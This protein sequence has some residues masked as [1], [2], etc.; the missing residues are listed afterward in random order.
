MRKL[1]INS[2]LIASVTLTACATDRN[3]LVPVGLPGVV[4]NLPGVHRINIQQGNLITQEMV[5]ELK[6]GMT[7]QQVRFLL[8]TPLLVDS[9]HPDRWD[10]LYTNR[11]ESK[12]A[13]TPVEQK[14]LSLFFKNERLVKITGDMYP[15]SEQMAKI[16]KEATRE[17]TVVIPPGTPKVNEDDLL[18][19]LVTRVSRYDD[20]EKSAPDIDAKE[21]G[22][23]GLFSRMWDAITDPF[24]DDEPETETKAEAA[25]E[26]TSE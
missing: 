23:P 1:L 21:R 11:P 9:F 25:E 26:T 13:R 12:S 17:K 7:K 20:P 19:R 10:Y 14:R 15:E 4:D 8:G 24:G 6:P 18:S 16:T 2:I 5:N 22:E 3:R